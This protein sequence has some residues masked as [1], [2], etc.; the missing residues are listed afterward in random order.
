MLYYFKVILQVSYVVMQYLYAIAID[1]GT[2]KEIFTFYNIRDLLE[3]S[4]K[5]G[6]HTLTQNQ[7]NILLLTSRTSHE[8]AY[9]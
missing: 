4:I 5:Q 1:L 8:S 2:F 9:K 3:N 6:Y 7:G